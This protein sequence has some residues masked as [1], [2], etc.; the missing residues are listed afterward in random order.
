MFA[1]EDEGSVRLRHR[2]APGGKRRRGW[3]AAR[4][5]AP[6]ARA[7]P[8]QHAAAYGGDDPAPQTTGRCGQA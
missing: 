7:A 3:P 5:R 1:G 6:L 8:A 2:G 4:R